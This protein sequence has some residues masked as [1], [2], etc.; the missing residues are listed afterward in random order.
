MALGVSLHM[1]WGLT[2]SGGDLFNPNGLHKEAA[3]EK[4]FL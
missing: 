1:L 2:P 3:A 4:T